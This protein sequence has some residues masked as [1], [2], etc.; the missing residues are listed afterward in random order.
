MSSNYKESFDQIKIPGS[1]AAEALDEVTSYVKPGVTTAKLDKI[2]YE[3]I[4]DNGGHSAPLYYRGFPKSSCTSVN[5]VV[6]HGIPADKYLKEGD[7]VNIDV[8]SIVN[9]WHG[10]TSRM[11]FVG[12][13]S[14]KS[15]KLVSATYNSMMKAISIIKSGIYLGD[16]GEA[17]QTYVEEK[18]FSV[19]R[20]FCGHGIGK[21]FH[22]PPNILHYGKKGEG[23]KLETGMIFTVEPMINEGLY[24]TKLLKD[25]WTAVTK[26]KSLSAQFE[27]T[28]G[29]TND[30]FEIFTKS[31]KNYKQ[32]PYLI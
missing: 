12:E 5:H 27:H 10:D 28:V 14:V 25:G 19:V 20:D 16:I 24:N 2:C 7:I 26:D 18:G 13:V 11:F 30:G 23:A 29:V 3:F 15:K 6:C 8:T 32:P 1:L 21:I 31:K 4:R 17:I 9:G 22:E